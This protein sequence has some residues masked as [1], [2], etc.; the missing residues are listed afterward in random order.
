MYVCMYVYV[1]FLLTVI[2]VIAV[3]SAVAGILILALIVG[4]IMRSLYVSVLF[5]PPTSVVVFFYSVVRWFAYLSAGM[6]A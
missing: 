5:L 6:L 4:L 2:I 1:C 3:V